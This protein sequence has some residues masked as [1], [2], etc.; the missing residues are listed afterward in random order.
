VEHPALVRG[1]RSL[2]HVIREEGPLL[3]QHPYQSYSASVERF[4]R[5]A[6]R[7]PKVRAIKMTLYRTD[8]GSK[9][10][11]HLVEAARNGKQVAVVVE[12]R[13]RF[14]EEANIRWANQLEEVGIHVTYGVMGLKTH[15]K[16]ILVVRQDYDG[17]R[18]Y[19]HVGTG[20]Y[21]ADTARIYADIGM[22]TS[23]R[24]IGQDVTELFNYLTT[25]Y[26][27]KRSYVKILPSPKLCKAG[28]LSRIEREI[29][30]QES[31]EPGLVEIKT[32]AL[33]DV[34][35]ARA[36]YRA[37]QAGV[38]VRLI[39]R[40]SC[41]MRPGLK[42]LSENVRIVSIVGRFLEH[43]RIY[44]FRNG[45]GDEY[46]IGSADCMSRNLES[47]VEMLVPVETVEL[48]KELRTMLDLQLAD[49]RSAWEMQPDGEYV[50]LRPRDEDEARS[51][52]EVLIERAAKRERQARRLKR[53]TPRG[54]NS[55]KR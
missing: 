8:A 48:R 42:G 32:N 40:D 9:A 22:F 39:V 36:L 27:P 5:E 26:K 2:F 53:R 20:N 24:L 52:Q 30:Y 49:R 50:Q 19:T 6:S 4:L 14:E 15:C 3:L 46:Y 45:G 29:E 13:A 10:I 44:H 11:E 54:P 17:L 28:L 33:E 18:R 35:V 25:G 47:R 51:S 41:R 34:D 55:R 23:D 31:G 1:D 43:A 38:E 16:A 7:D 12:L 21:N 37:S